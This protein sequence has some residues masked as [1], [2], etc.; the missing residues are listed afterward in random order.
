MEEW[1]FKEEPW[2]DSAYRSVKFTAER[3]GIR[4]I[5]AISQM[6]LNDYF[7]TEDTKEAAFSNYHEHSDMVHSLAIRMIQETAP[8]EQ[9]VFFITSDICRKYWL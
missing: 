4:H 8:N 9:G 7:R 5:C 6:A 2:W 3:A 1:E